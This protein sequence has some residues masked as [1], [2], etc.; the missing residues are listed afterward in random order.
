M[1]RLLSLSVVAA[2]LLS[3]VP[4]RLMAGDTG[5]DRLTMREELFG[6][7]AVGRLDIGDRAFCTGVL[8]ASDLVLTAAHCLSKAR[9]LGRV[10]DIV[11]RAGARDDQVIAAVRG[12]RAVIDSGYDPQAAISAETIS[13]DVALLQLETPIS[14]AIAAPFQL[15]ELP[16]AGRKVSVV[17]YGQ[18]RKDAPSRQAS[19]SV[20][21]RQQEL[22]AFSCDV[23]FGS[24]GAP[25]FDMSGWRARIVSLV[26]A[27]GQRNGAV[28]AFGMALPER[29]QA[30]KYAFR[31]GDGVFPKTSFTAR[32]ITIGSGNSTGA[33]FVRP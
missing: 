30:L 32:R 22:L 14:T 17:S 24:S 19:C 9:D 12:K 7:E 3:F 1:M 20:L 28:A 4:V 15:A 6:W 27:G 2:L 11:F 18:G 25:V 10:D 31:T 29:V 21:G 16:Q 8:I 23:T 5:L 13:H 26:S 33:H